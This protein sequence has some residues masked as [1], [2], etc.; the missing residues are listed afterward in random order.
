MFV[1]RLAA[2][3]KE[4]ASGERRVLNVKTDWFLEAMEAWVNDTGTR[5]LENGFTP[6][7][8]PPTWDTFLT[9]IEVGLI[10]E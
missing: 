6:I 5:E 7:P 8:D 9:M 4:I 10:Y 1:I 2:I 3:R